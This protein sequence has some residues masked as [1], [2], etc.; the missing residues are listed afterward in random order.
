MTVNYYYRQEW[1]PSGV[2]PNILEKTLGEWLEKDAKESIDRLI[3]EP[4]TLTAQDTAT[5]LV[6]LEVQRIRV[7]R[8]SDMAKASM[9]E[10]PYAAS[11]T[12]SRSRDS[13]R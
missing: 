11:A 5:L 2:D 10:T 4:S 9:R 3:H 7:P 1:V 12:R 6:Y 13:C 8:Q